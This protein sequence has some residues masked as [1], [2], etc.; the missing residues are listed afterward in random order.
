MD[1]RMGGLEDAVVAGRRVEGKV[2]RVV[3]EDV[4]LDS[5]EAS[6]GRKGG[7]ESLNDSREG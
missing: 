7:I 6:P 3:D 5:F 4:P 2:L 1:V